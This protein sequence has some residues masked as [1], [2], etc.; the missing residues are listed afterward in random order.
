MIK[1]IS[2]E[3]KKINPDIVINVHAVP[4][5]QDDFGGAVKIVAGQD[6]SQI[7]PHTDF[8]SP[9]T[10]AHM[11]KRSPS[12]VNSVV[13]DMD[14]VAECRILPSIQVKEAYLSDVLSV[15]EFRETLKEALKPP[16]NG[17]IFWSW[18]A[19]EKD[20]PKKG[21]IRDVLQEN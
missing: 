7:S 11:V 14:K 1:T 2:D 3:A 12:W 15:S 9:M 6:I 10:Y 8:L 17:V 5:R 21:L 13:K 20:F 16:S 19:L 4:W 18:E